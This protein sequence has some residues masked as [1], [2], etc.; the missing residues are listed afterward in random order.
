M[1]LSEL[2][3]CEIVKLANITNGEDWE[4]LRP[5]IAE[6][7]ARR[8]KIEKELG[9]LATKSTTELV[10]EGIMDSSK[11]QTNYNEL[12]SRYDEVETMSDAERWRYKLALHTLEM[13]I[14]HYAEDFNE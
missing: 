12:E 7:L 4:L 14:K 9:C 2:T 11:A 1:E 13:V 3:T 10:S 6:E 8:N 5:Q